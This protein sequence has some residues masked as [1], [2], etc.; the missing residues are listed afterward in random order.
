MMMMKK[1]KRIK[2]NKRNG[3]ENNTI[4][5]KTSTENLIIYS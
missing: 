3:K 1:G 4:M 2:K 5:M